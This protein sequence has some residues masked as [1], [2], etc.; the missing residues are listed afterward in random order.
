MSNEV[1]LKNLVEKDNDLIEL[2]SIE[3][4]SICMGS[5]KKKVQKCR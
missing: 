1:P 5:G 2:N 4:T 3:D